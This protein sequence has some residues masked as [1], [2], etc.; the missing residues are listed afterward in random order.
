MA[1]EAGDFD[2]L[3]A[4]AAGNDPALLRELRAGFAESLEQQIDLL[5]RARCDANWT[6]AAQRLKSLGASFHS[7]D[8]DGLAELALDSAPGD[9]GIVRRFERFLE[10]FL[11]Q[12]SG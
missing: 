6:V 3:L 1:Y 11:A 8:L 7:P 12:S 5:R 10:R 4:A 9:P 2:T